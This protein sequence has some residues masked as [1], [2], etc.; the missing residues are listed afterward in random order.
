MKIIE[1]VLLIMCY[2]SLVIALFL[3]F[4]CYGRKI[5][6]KETIAFT[7]S[8]LLLVLSIS[9]SPVIGSIYGEL[10]AILLNLICMLTVSVTTFLNV[11]SER[12]HTIPKYVI[13][14][15]SSLAALLLISS[16]IGYAM[17]NLHTIQVAVIIFLILSVIPSMLIVFNTKPKKEFAHLEKSEKQF[18]L[19]FIILIPIVVIFSFWF[20]EQYSLLQLG[21]V[22]PVIFIILAVNKIKD[23]LKRLSI[24]QGTLEPNQQKFKNYNFTKREEEIALLLFE[25]HTY[26]RISELLFISLPTVKTHASNVYKKSGVKTRHELVSFLIN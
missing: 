4:I 11:L 22:M 7:F 17:S 21:F 1:L 24:I 5:E 8:L 25:G 14:I 13:V 3:E 16:V 10:S 12:K 20:E 6:T 26:Q 18:A 2:S 15:H 23:N 9:F 19:S